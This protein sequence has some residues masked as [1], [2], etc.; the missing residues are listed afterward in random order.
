MPAIFSVLRG[1]IR[2]IGAGAI[3]VGAGQLSAQDKPASNADAF[4][5]YDSYIQISGQ[6]P[7]ITGDR[8]AFAQRS[9]LPNTGTGGIESLNYS[10][11][12]SDSTT[13]LVNGRFLGGS[14]DYLASLN[15][16]DSSIGTVDV[17]YKRFRTFYD[18]VGGF[19]PLADQFQAFS[20]ESLHVDRSTFWVDTKLARPN[21]PVFTLSFHDEIRTG[22]KDSTEWAPEVNPLAV[23]VARALV[24][25][26]LP[27]NTPEVAPNVMTLDEHHDILSASMVLTAGK[28][29]ET[30]KA[31]IDTVNNADGREYVKYPNSAVIA[32][33][34]VTV[35]DDLETIRSTSFR[36]LNQTETK[37]SDQFAADV[38]LTYSQLSSANGGFWI[39]PAYSATA[40]AI[41]PA[42]TAANIYGGSKFSDYIGNASLKYTPTKSWLADLAFRDEYNVT[43]SNGGFTTTTL[44]AGA[45][46][47]ASTKVTVAD[48]LTYSHFIEHVAT[49]EL[50][51]EYL[52]FDRLSLYGS[53]DDRVDHG[54]QHWINPYAAVTTTGM[55]GTVTTAG[56]PIGSVFFQD[57][58][59]NNQDAKLGAN[60]NAAKVLTIRAEIFRKDHQ[61]QFIGSNDIIGTASYGALYVTGYTFTGVKL[62][63]ILK[64][65]PTLTFSTR[66]QPQ[67]GMVSVTGN[68]V[69]GGSGNEVTSGKV[70]GQMISETVDYTPSPQIYLQGNAN[71]VYNYIQTAYPVVVVSATTN[72]PTPIQNADNNYITTSGL[73]GFVLDKTTDAQIQAIWSKAN[74]YNPQIAPG[75][76]PY[77]ASFLEESVTAGLK[78]K[79][80]SRMMAD[81]KVGYL[82][83]TDDTTGGFTNYRGPLVYISFTYSL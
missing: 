65:S 9:D 81:G 73:C 75:G 80:S 47:T 69:T 52:G 21:A 56:A 31:T 2:L 62:S 23:V 4:P 28:T 48:D 3:L 20:P 44:A 35:Q 64:P 63:V 10:K 60:W 68:A 40:N 15:L 1:R 27:T 26:A 53:F 43:A 11:D 82:R 61:N 49:P 34:A 38:G 33:P 79:F 14:D 29:T 19:F 36:L 46:S 30:L 6:E 39:T 78:H 72:I 50:S 16:T 18:G 59:Q 58:D 51:L 8:A 13:L 57:A 7:W 5:T 24:G 12:L 54:D 77:G 22:M 32:D 71:V 74:N 76:Q 17:G 67:Q 41:Y 70:S 66:Y 25:T 37:F 83:L 45:T 42:E 55:T